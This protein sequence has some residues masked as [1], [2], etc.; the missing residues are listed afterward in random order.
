MTSKIIFSITLAVL[1]LSGCNRQ[2]DSHEHGAEEHGHSHDES[3]L[4]PL[5][6]TLYSDHFELF[7]EFKPLIVGQQSK[8]AAHFT[9]LGE[10]FTALAAGTVTV[11]L[12]VEEKGIR[13]Q[14]DAP[15][16]PGIYRLALTPGMAGIGKLVFDIKTKN[17]TDQLIIDSVR[18]FADEQTA[19]AQQP[20]EASA[21]IDI[22]YLKEQAWKVEFATEPL[23]PRPFGEI[24]QTTGKIQPAPGDEVVVAATLD[25]I[26]Q[27]K[28]RPLLV[29][30]AIRSGEPLVTL[31]S[32]SLAEGNLDARLVQARTNF[33]R[34]RTDFERAQQLITNQLITSRDFEVRKAELENARTALEALS[35][36][37]R[38]GGKSLTAPISGYIKNVLVEPGQYVS[39][40]QPLLTLTRNRRLVIRADVSQQDVRLLSQIQS[41]S[42]RTPSDNQR[43]SLEQL[44]GRIL[45]Y[46]RSAEGQSG[47]VP[48]L[49][50]VTNVG[51]LVPGTFVDVWLKTRPQQSVLAVPESALIEEQG[52]YYV[53]VQTGGESFQKRE[54]RLGVRDGLLVQ[55]LS[56]VQPG[57]RVVTKG[58]YQIRLSSL[59][60]TL[61]AHG[62]EH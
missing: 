34:A 20:K 30:G 8:F 32:G 23:Q 51:G 45:S 16:V 3:G 29:G 37:Y 25:G 28:N 55:L 39:V 41:A 43:Y 4:Q 57:E 5:A 54:V 33:E 19:L 7:V 62:H 27:L 46:G 35:A 24:I 48:L 47:F 40:G 38:A 60:G 26:V 1:F 2:S 11:S 61:P 17:A 9:V 53:Y 36:N 6:Y 14:A 59:S 13:Q 21:G 49:M 58:G 12:L 44:Q 52:I 22:T 56:G 50:E 18:V 42:I 31:T 10:K 15:T